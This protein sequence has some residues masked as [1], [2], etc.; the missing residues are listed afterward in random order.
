[1]L[2]ID[3]GGTR[4]RVSMTEVLESGRRWVSDPIAFSRFMR[5]L[6]LSADAL[7]DKRWFEPAGLS[8]NGSV[9]RLVMHEI[10]PVHY[11][12]S[13][14]RSIGGRFALR[15]TGVA[16][17]TVIAL[18]RRV[19]TLAGLPIDGETGEDVV[20]AEMSG[21][22]FQAVFNELLADLAERVR[23]VVVDDERAR[24]E[25]RDSAA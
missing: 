16:D 3:M 12:S 19:V 24:S 25:A 1:M 2:L 9:F 17:F 18:N 15:L 8:R 14:L 21:P 13:Y 6:R 4:A 7:L 11:D 20:D 5:G 10:L 23:A 22:V